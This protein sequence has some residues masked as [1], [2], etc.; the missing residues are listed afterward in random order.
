VPGFKK[1]HIALQE[2]LGVTCAAA[3]N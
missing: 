1:W 3:M 2:V